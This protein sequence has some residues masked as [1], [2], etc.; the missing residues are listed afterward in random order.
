MNAKVLLLSA[1]VTTLTL[2]SFAAEPLL[3]PRAK[4]NR[5]KVS[6][7]AGLPVPSVAYVEPAPALLSPRDQASQSKVVKGT[8]LDYNPYLACRSRM[9]G[10]PKIVAA[11]SDNP[12]LSACA[13]VAML[14]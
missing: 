2:A 11:C 5:I 1:V 14:K 10:S 9:S 8:R 6:S 7:F 12:A 4:D 13:S 3:S